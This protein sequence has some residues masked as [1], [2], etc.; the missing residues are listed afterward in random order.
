LKTILLSI[1]IIY[2]FVLFAQSERKVSFVVS[3]SANAQ[4][5]SFAKIS[6]RTY[7]VQYVCDEDGRKTITVQDSCLIKISAIGY[8]D[9]YSLSGEFADDTIKIKMLPKVYQLK[10]FTL[11]P[12]P[13]VDLF[14]QAF[15]D[16]R[17]PDTNAFEFNM[18][19][20]YLLGMKKNIRKE[21]NSQ[22]FASVSFAS[23]I[24]GLYNLFSSKVKSARKLNQLLGK[25][26]RRAQVYK[27]YNPQLVKT[28][29]G[30]KDQETL[31]KMMSF[32]LPPD[33]FVLSASDYDLAAFI[34]DCYEEFLI[35]NTGY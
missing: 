31:K 26:R 3:G 29:T 1:F 11:S 2:S 25:D 16:L 18:A 32:C 15:L 27:R 5:I 33:T 28:I 22:E 19:P 6:D 14:K 34:L 10:E 21:Y 24:S 12:Y 17:I 23:P 8:Y 9:F 7:N 20:L 30:I 35:A 13:T 4:R